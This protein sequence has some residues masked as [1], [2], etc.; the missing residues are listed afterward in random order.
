MDSFARDNPQD[1]HRPP[2]PREEGTDEIFSLHEPPRRRW[3]GRATLGDQRLEATL[4]SAGLVLRDD[5]V[6]VAGRWALSLLTLTMACCGV[7]VMGSKFGFWI[8]D[9]RAER[10]L[11]AAFIAAAAVWP[12]LAIW[13]ALRA[14]PAARTA[15]LRARCRLCIWCGHDLSGR[16]ATSLHCPECGREIRTR[17]A[18]ILWCRRLRPRYR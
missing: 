17:D 12:P 9:I 5:R 2:P 10:T 11:M 8:I 1:E 13:W 18:V 6:H 7:V 3:S 14:G 16:P 15:L 4:P